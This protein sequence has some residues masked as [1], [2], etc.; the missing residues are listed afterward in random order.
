VQANQT[1]HHEH[2]RV[3]IVDDH[4]VYR[5]GLQTVLATEEGIE[6]VGEA[7]DGIEAVE[8][9][10]ETLPDVIVMDVSMPKR[11]GIEACRVIKQRVPSVR[12]LMLT[13]SDDESHL[14]EAVRAGANGYLLKDVP[15]EEVA[16][17]IRGLH[18]GQSLLSPMMAS[19][20][21]IEFAQISDRADTPAPAPALEVPRLTARELEI[22][23]QVAQGRG[24]REIAT[25]L[26][27]SENTVRNHIRNILDKLQMHSRMEAAMFAVRERLIDPGE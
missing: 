4:A 16:A 19:K 9:A 17:G 10:E 21:L 6:V 5:R 8:R 11:G 24:N 3:L 25:K 2:I 13:S 15:P 26:F 1:E 20:L 27:I 23:R 22:L 14:F 18:H 12:I 7:A